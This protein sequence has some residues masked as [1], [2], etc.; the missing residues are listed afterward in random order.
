MNIFLTPAPPKAWESLW[1]R[2]RKIVRARG[3]GD[4]KEMIFR[5]QLGSCDSMH[6]LDQI[7]A[8][9]W[10]VGTKSHTLAKELL[11]M[12]SCWDRESYYYYYYF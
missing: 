2:S 9:R 8:W 6:S 5:K 4:C 3:S 1:K 7:P 11:V 12:I 10:E